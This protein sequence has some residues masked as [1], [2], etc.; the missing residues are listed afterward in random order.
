MSSTSHSAHPLYAFLQSDPGRMHASEDAAHGHEPSSHPETIDSG[1]TGVDRN[2]NKHMISLLTTVQAHSNQLDQMVNHLNSL[3]GRV[4]SV[5]AIFSEG[6][7]QIHQS[8]AEFKADT[9]KIALQTADRISLTLQPILNLVTESLSTVNRRLETV[10][11]QAE[12]Q[13]NTQDNQGLIL[14]KVEKDAQSLVIQARSLE[15]RLDS[16]KKEQFQAIETLQNEFASLSSTLAPLAH[17]APLLKAFLESQL[18]LPLNCEDKW[19]NESYSHGKIRTTTMPRH[20]SSVSRSQ[21]RERSTAETSS[22]RPGTHTGS[23]K[24]NTRR[25]QSSDLLGHP[26]ESRSGGNREKNKDVWPTTVTEGESEDTQ[27]ITNR[28]TEIV[29]SQTD[30]EHEPTVT[31][32]SEIHANEETLRQDDPP[33]QVMSGSTQRVRS[34]H[35]GKRGSRSRKRSQVSPSST[36]E[37]SCSID[38]ALRHQKV[39]SRKRTTLCTP[40]VLQQVVRSESIS[41]TQLRRISI[42]HTAQSHNP[43]SCDTILSQDSHQSHRQSEKEVAP[44]HANLASHK[45]ARRP[46]LLEDHTS[47]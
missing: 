6:Q 1:K 9:A 29:L 43:S 23:L 13:R 14:A 33:D 32:T 41:T 28:E 34:S 31:Q 11:S 37:E 26:R 21:L 44:I 36:Q 40:A 46:L 7:E 16:V 3:V 10:C 35:L 45:K 27:T 19:H 12:H 4:E 22:E 47:T 2:S 18:R 38:V 17:M 24:F 15:S 8:V 25:Q 39:H 20:L 42:Q 5:E 30:A